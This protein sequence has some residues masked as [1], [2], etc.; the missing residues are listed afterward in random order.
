L[1]N[2]FPDQEIRPHERATR[3]ITALQSTERSKLPGKK[4][5]TL[6]EKFF[7]LFHFGI[8]SFGRLIDAQTDRGVF[9]TLS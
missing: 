2:R 9:V 3:F 1:R 7:Q 4:R 8:I 5:D 6:P